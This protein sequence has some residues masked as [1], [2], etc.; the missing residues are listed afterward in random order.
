MSF[1]KELKYLLLRKFVTP[2]ACHFLRLYGRLLFFKVEGAE[3]F[4]S[5]LAAGGR[6]VFACWHQRFFG[7]FYFPG[8]FEL[9]P[10]IMISRSRDGDFIADAVRR[11]G[12]QPVRGSSSREGK[13]ALREMVERVSGG[14]VGVHIV[15]GPN[16]PAGVVKPGLV[17]LAQRTGSAV[18]LGLVSYEAPLVFN[19]WDRFMIPR[20]FT[21]VLINLGRIEPV[22]EKMEPDEF[23]ACRRRIEDSLARGYAETDAYWGRKEN[24]KTA[25]RLSDFRKDPA[26]LKVIRGG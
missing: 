6:I 1:R 11:I 14:A 23:E 13:R 16:G 18:C 8:L 3:R 2:P 26:W 21:R 15:D 5:H 19:S 12:W 10:F 17:T 20:P 9:S 4:L 7:G 22:P 24:R 25:R